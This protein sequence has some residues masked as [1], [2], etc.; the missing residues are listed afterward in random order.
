MFQHTQRECNAVNRK[1]RLLNAWGHDAD[2]GAEIARRKY[3]TFFHTEDT[4]ED[5]RPR[6][7]RPDRTINAELADYEPTPARHAPHRRVE[8]YVIEGARLDQALAMQVGESPMPATI[9]G[10]GNELFE[11]LD[12]GVRRVA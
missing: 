1:R 2:R 10:K 9:F 7:R 4:F 5:G 12:G 8:R 11:V 6:L 3:S